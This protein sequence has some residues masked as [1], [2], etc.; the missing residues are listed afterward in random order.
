M[1]KTSY[2]WISGDDPVFQ[3]FYEITEAYYSQIAGGADRR[4]AFVPYNASDGIPDVAIAFCGSQAVGCAGLKRYSHT[5]AEI[6]RLWVEPAFRGRHIA[7]ALMALIEEKARQLGYR[8][9]I[10]QTRPVMADAVALYIGRGYCPIPNYPPYDRLD[11]AV[12]YAKEI[13]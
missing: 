11:G 7:S 4:R 12:C 8:R 6:K 9:V 1:M 10:L 3:H 13:Q 5:D 2:Q